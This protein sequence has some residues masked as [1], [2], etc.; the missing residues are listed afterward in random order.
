MIEMYDRGMIVKWGHV[1]WRFMIEM[2]LSR[3]MYDGHV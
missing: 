3:D 1:R 2:I